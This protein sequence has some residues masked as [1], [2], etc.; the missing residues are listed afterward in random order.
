[1][2]LAQLGDARVGL[3][4]V[5]EAAVGAGHALVIVNH[6]GRAVLIIRLAGGFEGGIGFPTFREREGL[7]AV[8]ECVA[9][10]V[11]YRRAE[12][13]SPDFVG[14]GLEGTECGVSLI[15]IYVQSNRAH[16]ADR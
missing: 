2:Q 10:I 13:V 8:R 1:M 9:Q 4:D 7:E 12:K 11:L 5:V 14:A 3:V 16:V 15:G 6:E